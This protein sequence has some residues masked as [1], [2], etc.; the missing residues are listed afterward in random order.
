MKISVIVPVYNIASYIS[1]CIDSIIN[2]SYKNLEIIL[3]NDGSNDNSLD[4][5]SQ[6]AKNDNRI[7]IIDKPNGGLSSAR[8]AGME[9]STGDYISFIDG[10]DW[11]SH[12]MYQ[13]LVEKATYNN[14]PDILVFG[15]K[16]Y[17]STEKET[18][19]SYEMPEKVFN[20]L[21]FYNQSRYYVNAWS[22]IYKRVYLKEKEIKF[23]EGIIY[24]DIPFTIP[25]IIEAAS[26][27][28]IDEPFY[29]YRQAREG[30]ILNTI[31]EKRTHDHYFVYHLQYLYAEK[32]DFKILKLNTT[33]FKSMLHL[34]VDRSIPD[35][36]RKQLCEKFGY[37]KKIKIISQYASLNPIIRYI[38][39]TYPSLLF[40]IFQ[41]KIRI[42]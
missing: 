27:L 38:A 2:Q 13:K 4:I 35:T 36:L 39:K 7:K 42:K 21:D 28:Y 15:I 23:I 33:T 12:D 18:I 10:D 32:K 11:I 40:F 34:S 6:Y 19:L 3:V 24:E 8:N 9:I 41:L 22:K 26:V 31:N 37:T 17:W 1:Q 30:S 25:C 16:R 14:N 29:Y 5:I 20:G